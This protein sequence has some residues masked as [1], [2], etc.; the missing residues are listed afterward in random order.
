MNNETEEYT[1]DLAQVG[2][3]PQTI[4]QIQ[5]DFGSQG[6][7]P[8]EF[9]KRAGDPRESAPTQ[10]NTITEDELGAINADPDGLWRVKRHDSYAE[11]LV[12]KDGKERRIEFIEMKDGY[13]ARV[14]IERTVLVNMGKDGPDSE[15]WKSIE[16]QMRQNDY[17]SLG[18]KEFEGDWIM[19]LERNSARRC[20]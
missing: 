13:I 3:G 17:R 6:L 1:V 4:E 16:E 18:P 12:D 15:K 20:V 2:Y 19:C 8:M 9:R 10:E 14:G 11:I 7:P 5:A